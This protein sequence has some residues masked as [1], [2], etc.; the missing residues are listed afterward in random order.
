VTIRTMAPRVILIVVLGVVIA[1]L[2]LMRARKQTVVV[3]G[4]HDIERK[5]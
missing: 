5:T 4:P 1:V 3:G 2:A